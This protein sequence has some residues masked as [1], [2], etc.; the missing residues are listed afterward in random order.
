MMD[1]EKLR[2]QY[3]KNGVVVL[4]DFLPEDWI[5]RGI[6]GVENIF[7]HPSKFAQTFPYLYGEG[8]Y[9]RDYG[10]WKENTDIREL[11]FKSPIAKAVAEVVD[12]STITLYHDQTIVKDAGNMSLVGFQ[13]RMS[14][15]PFTGSQV[16]Y[17]VCNP[18]CQT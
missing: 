7:S 4:R 17:S 5:Q 3:K 16:T 15:Y 18:V 10:N 8:S 1:M 11:I 6:A 14:N 13:Q 12:T 2:L 9:F